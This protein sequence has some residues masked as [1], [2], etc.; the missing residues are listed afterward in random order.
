MAGQ[1]LRTL[2]IAYKNLNGNEDLK[3]KDDKG[4]YQIEK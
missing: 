3:S 2:C 4:V 1:A